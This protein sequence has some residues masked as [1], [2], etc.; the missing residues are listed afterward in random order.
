MIFSLTLLLSVAHLVLLPGTETENTDLVNYEDKTKYHADDE[1]CGNVDI[2]TSYDCYCENNKFLIKDNHCCVNTNETQCYKDDDY[3]QNGHCESGKVKNINDKCNSKC[4][5]SYQHSQFLYTK[6]HYTCPDSCVPLSS[7][8]S[9]IDF[10]QQE[11]HECKEENLRCQDSCVPG[12]GWHCV[13][14][15]YTVKTLQTE[16]VDGHAYCYSSDGAYNNDGKYDTISRIDEDGVTFEDSE[17]VDYQALEKC[18]A[19]N[20]PYTTTDG[21]QCGDECIHSYKL[22]TNED[23][24][25][26]CTISPNVSISV[27]NPTL[28]QDVQFLSKISCDIYLSTGG[29]A[30]KGSH[31]TGQIQHCVSGWYERW[32]VT[33]DD[34]WSP[35]VCEDKSDQ[36][37]KSETTCSNISSE[38]LTQYQETFCWPSWGRQEPQRWLK[39]EPQCTDGEAWLGKQTDILYTDPHN[40]QG[41]CSDDERSKGLDCQSCTNPDYFQCLVDVTCLHP[42][43]RCDGHPQCSDLSDEEDCYEEYLRRG[44]IRD[45]STF[46][47]KSKNYPGK[48][49]CY[50]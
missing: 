22:C 33:I 8:C 7:M 10:C 24:T 2:S 28:C 30:F 36:V 9:G 40:C 31:C 44:I 34:T 47:C 32:T 50:H 1:K 37:I 23:S 20:G 45:S 27:N 19:S 48:D 6:A 42:D 29:L 35:P 13:P 18:Q 16:L 39:Y 11:L 15:T 14:T 46:E 38:Y 4:Y 5:N 21:L 17:V 26:E 12:D 3:P 41:S 43:L 25:K 49:F